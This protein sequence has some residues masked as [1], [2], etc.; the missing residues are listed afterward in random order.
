MERRLH[1]ERLMMF[2][3]SQRHDEAANRYSD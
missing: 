1:F 2:N 3:A